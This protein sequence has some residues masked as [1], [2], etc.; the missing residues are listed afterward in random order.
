[1]QQIPP[2]AASPDRPTPVAPPPSPR[3][4][5]D[6]ADLVAHLQSLIVDESEEARQC[7]AIIKKLPARYK[8]SYARPKSHAH[9]CKT[10]V[11]TAI[12]NERARTNQNH[13]GHKSLHRPT[14]ILLRRSNSLPNMIRTVGVMLTMPSPDKPVEEMG[15][16]ERQMCVHHV[17]HGGEDT[18]GVGKLSC[19]EIVDGHPWA[20]MA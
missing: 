10:I 7:R 3:I 6:D 5:E 17:L 11:K 4:I 12:A 15:Q 2:S 16:A 19:A 13:I 1:M 8:L 9:L 18:W 20:K 14:P